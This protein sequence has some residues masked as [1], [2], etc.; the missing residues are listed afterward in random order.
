MQKFLLLGAVLRDIAAQRHD[1]FNMVFPECAEH[2]IYRFPGA[3]NAGEVRQHGGSGA[4]LQIR[5]DLHSE[6]RGSACGAIGDADKIRM[7]GGNLVRRLQSG[8]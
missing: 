3:G 4:A 2:F 1:V 5:G 6:S 7:Q 8:Q